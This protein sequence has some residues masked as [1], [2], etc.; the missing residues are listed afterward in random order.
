MFTGIVKG[1]APIAALDKKKSLLRYAITFPPDSLIGLECGASVAIDGV[2][3]TVVALQK[4]L[5]W[6]EAIEETLLRT[7][8]SQ[9]EIGSRVNLE[10][11]AKIGDE[12]GGHLLS[13]HIFG[14]VSL[15][16]IKENI[17]TLECS[18]QGI[19]YLFSKG[20]VALDGVSLTLVDVDKREGWFSVHLISETLKRT[21]LGQKKVGA[22][23]N[24]ELD[25]LTQ[26]AVDT[27]EHFLLAAQGG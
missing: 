23:L 15:I 8:L 13:G 16:D 25:P 20:S 1:V 12:I 19:K 21:T 26:A 17:Y 3:Q 2:C 5:V 22:L 18:A 24:L 7:T 6:F 27:I 14:R 4:D 9:M 10:R 11:A